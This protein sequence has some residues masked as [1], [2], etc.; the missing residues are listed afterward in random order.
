[1]A[2]TPLVIPLSKEELGH[3]LTA[4]TAFLEQESF[5][6]PDF[7]MVIKLHTAAGSEERAAWIAH[8]S[9]L[10][11]AQE[12]SI[13]PPNVP[14]VA[15]PDVQA[16]PRKK[17]KNASLNT[18]LNT[19]SNAL[20]GTDDQRTH[21]KIRQQRI[22]DLQGAAQPGDIGPSCTPKSK[23]AGR[24][25][26]KL[27]D[28]LVIEEV[29][30]ADTEKTKKQQVITYCIGCNHREAYQNPGRIRKHA[31]HDC[32]KLAKLFPSYHKAVCEELAGRANGKGPLPR[33]RKIT[34]TAAVS[35]IAPPGS[36]PSSSDLAEE[37][38]KMDVDAD[39]PID[40]KAADMELGSGTHQGT[41]LKYYKPIKMTD[42]CQAAIDLALFQLIICAALPFSFVGN[43][44]LVNLLL[45]AVPNYVTPDRSAFFTRHLAEQLAAFT[46]QLKAFLLPYCYLTLSLDGWSS[47]GHDEIYT[48]HTTLPSR[49]SNFTLGH[50]FGTVSTTADALVTVAK[51]RI[52]NIFGAR[53]YSAVV[54]DGASN[55]RSMWKEIARKF[56]WIL[57]IYDPCHLL[58][59]FL[60][61]IG[62][63]FKAELSL[64]S[65]ICNYFAHSN[66]A[67]QTLAAKQ[68]CQNIKTGLKSASDTRFGTSFIQTVALWLCFPAIVA[69]YLAGTILFNTAAT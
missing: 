53:V 55:V 51:E 67:M 33:V 18:S 69:C 63:L 4:R 2:S 52:F 60:K 15:D 21:E 10:S 29:V 23:K 6:I 34:K 42:V 24:K 13:V 7:V 54:T 22:L 43:P 56:P 59:L 46:V 37:G 45:V 64:V 31:T 11:N 36:N 38:I 5:S 44:W 50:V 57:N 17:S 20:T 39:A 47:R 9:M 28:N 58:N 66:I 19:L 65:G 61:D 41:I 1:M 48:F 14:G 3:L 25:G 27:V 62:K 49:R 32:P 8:V 16:K 40:P 35:P 26:D 30:Y 12:Q 68:E